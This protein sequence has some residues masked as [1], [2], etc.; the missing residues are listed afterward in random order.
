MECFVGWLEIDDI[1]RY[2]LLFPEWESSYSSSDG[3]SH[4]DLLEKLAIY[5]FSPSNNISQ[6][7]SSDRLK[8]FVM[9]KIQG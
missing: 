4:S 9:E 3:I 8:S 1:R 2:Q 7:Y 6:D 5:V